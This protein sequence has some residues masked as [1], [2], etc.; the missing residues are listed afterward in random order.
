MINFL[1]ENIELPDFDQTKIS[2]WV[3][4]ITAQNGK[5]LGQINYIFCDDAKILEINN[6]Y[7]RHDYYTDIITFD[8]SSATSIKGDIF[9]S[10]TTVSSNAVNLDIDFNNEL[11]RV[12]IHGILHLCGQDDKTPDSKSVMRL[13]ENDALEIYYND[14]Q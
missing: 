7:L 1:S 8:Y 4:I 3:K 10:V 12:I 6:R 11:L 14:F 5:K 2:Q 9:I 13:R